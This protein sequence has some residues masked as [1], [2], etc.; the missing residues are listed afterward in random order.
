MTSPPDAVRQGRGWWRANR[1]SLLALLLLV[2]VTGGVIAGYEWWDYYFARPSFPVTPGKDGTVALAGASWGPARAVVLEDTT[3][4]TVPPG[5]KVIGV[6]VPVVPDDP[7]GEP[8]D[9]ACMEP[10]LVQQSTGRR[11][12]PM[13]FELGLRFSDDEPETCALQGP[14]PFELVLPYIVPEDVQGPFWID[15]T[16]S[17]SYPSF[18]RFPVDP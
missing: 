7:D 3:G 17:E 11:W 12:E 13:R 14:E 18:P 1:L 10:M 16:S 2:P 6:G 5:T 9:T 4:L 8:G 15:I